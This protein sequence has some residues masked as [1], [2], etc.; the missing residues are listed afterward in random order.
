MR[1]V[2]ILV[3][4]LDHKD[5]RLKRLVSKDIIDFIVR[6]KEFEDLDKRLTA[7]EQRLEGQK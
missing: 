7:I 6:H 2:E 1:A 5:D 4:L 3:A